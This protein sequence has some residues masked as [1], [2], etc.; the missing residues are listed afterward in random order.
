MVEHTRDG[1]H[2]RFDSYIRDV[3]GILL[4]LLLIILMMKITVVAP[5]VVDI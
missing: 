3:R 1:A 5:F 2:K 4:L